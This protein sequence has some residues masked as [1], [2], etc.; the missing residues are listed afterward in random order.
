V[1]MMGKRGGFFANNQQTDLLEE[2]INEFNLAFDH[3]CF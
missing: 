2:R 1:L 3:I